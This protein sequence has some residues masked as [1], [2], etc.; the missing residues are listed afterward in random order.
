[1]N[2]WKQI[3]TALAGVVLLAGCR[4]PTGALALL[5]TPMAAPAPV[6]EHLAAALAY[7][8]AATETFA[9]TNWAML[10]AEAGVASLSSADPMEQRAD[11]LRTVGLETQAL[12]SGYGR[13]YFLTHA[14]TWGWDSTD[15]LWESTLTLPGGGP[16]FVLRLRDDFD[17]APLLARFEERGFT[18]QNHGAV[19]I[20]S[21]EMDLSA[22]WLR[23]T[24]FA[25]LNTAVL[26]DQ[27]LLVLASTPESVAAVLDAQ[28]T[29]ATL[30]NLPTV[31]SVAAALGPVGAAI[32]SP[33][34]CEPL[35]AA[36]L[37]N[38]E[39]RQQYTE[40]WQQAG[41]NG[42]YTTLGIGYRVEE[43]D[44]QEIQ[45]GVVV[46]YFPEEGAAAADLGPRRQ[47]AEEGESLRTRA[48]YAELFEVVDAYVEGANLVITLHAHERPPQLFFNMFY[49]R[50]LL[51]AAC[52]GF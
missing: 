49:Q 24:E 51:F 46:M 13:H 4:L 3:I 42:L 18:R 7:A 8:P 47:L 38:E 50:D 48:P 22:D 39:V 17:F 1:M 20:Y 52:G 27:H 19:P 29:G 16:L 5:P 11:F 33:L 30:A 10:K 37:L 26:A 15:L 44:G 43:I 35:D 12:A 25:I 41:I 34:G 31:H 40:M 28:A 32:L 36:L 45:A 23:T 2:P 14:E 9:F 21:H 6:S